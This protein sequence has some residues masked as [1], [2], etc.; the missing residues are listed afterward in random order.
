MARFIVSYTFHASASDS[1]EAASKE[2]AERLVSERI[3]ADDFQLDAD[4]IDDVDFS[5]QEFHPVTRDGKQM[6]TTHVRD[7]DTPGHVEAGQ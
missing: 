6:W 2:E 4:E 5:V 7:G 3:E 1:I